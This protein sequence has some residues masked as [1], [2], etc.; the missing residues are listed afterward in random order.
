[1][2]LYNKLKSKEKEIKMKDTYNSPLTLTSQ[3]R[4][5]GNP[6][7]LDFY[8][9]CSF[10]CKYCFARH[11][12]GRDDFEYCYAKFEIIENL[13]KKAFEKD[14][15]AKNYIVELLRHRVPIHVGGLADPFQPVEFKLKLNYKMIELSNKY[16]YPLIFSTKTSYLPDEYFKILNP[17]LHAF[18]ISLIGAD[19]EWIKQYED[20]SPSA[21]DRINFL[22][23]LR[24]KGFWCSIR[25]QPLIDLDKAIELCE[26]IDGVASYITIEH[27]KINTDNPEIKELFKEQINKYKRTSIMRNLE[28]DI[29]EK[30]T[31]IEAIKKHLKKTPIGV[32]DNDLHYLS[33]SRCC[34]GVDTIG[35]NFN[36]WLKYNLTYFTTEH[37][38][39]KKVIDEELWIPKCN[40]ANCVNVDIRIK[41]VSNFKD[42]VDSYC[43][44][45][46]Y[47]MCDGCSMKKRLDGIS[48]NKDNGNKQ[49]QI[50][51]FSISGNDE[52]IESEMK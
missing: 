45:Y 26:I 13:F 14:D 24:S 7:R 42:Y 40:I 38:N 47:F 5:C 48:F 11:I 17:K 2:N 21:T 8:K 31:N 34:C 23:T 20:N 30:T 15:E 22:K 3:F 19:D 43:G 46:N 27:L 12:G 32:G 28:L 35:E 49:Q 25:I 36:N 52:L 50:S 10:G 29:K 18:Q 44:K 1:M 6:F 37:L 4:F 33:E 51:I 16:N 9:F 39:S 41:N